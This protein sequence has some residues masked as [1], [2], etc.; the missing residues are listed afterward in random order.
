[1]SDVSSFAVT[2]PSAARQAAPEAPLDLSVPHRFLFLK[3]RW[4]TGAGKLAQA[5]LM[6]TTGVFLMSQASSTPGLVL[7]I[8]IVGTLL[9]IAGVAIL[10]HAWSDFVGALT[11][12][13]HELRARLGWSKF[14]VQWPAVTSWQINDDSANLADLTSVE[15][16]TVGSRLPLTL[17]GGR[18][19]VQDLHRMRRL[20]LAFAENAENE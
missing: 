2:L 16:C 15:I 7:Q 8:A 20:F 1:M 6:L 19:N 13:Q 14:A 4:L 10:A 5:G 11:I 17:P 18:F 12:D 3:Q 9:A